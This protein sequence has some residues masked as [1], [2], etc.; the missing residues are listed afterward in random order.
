LD[1]E[2]SK[3]K[4]APFGSAQMVLAQ[5]NCTVCGGCLLTRVAHLQKKSRNEYDLADPAQWVFFFSDLLIIMIGPAGLLLVVPP[6][7]SLCPS[8][9]LMG[10][11]AKKANN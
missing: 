7:L 6:H 4:S 5:H 8:F 3:K 11:F 2:K 10:G 1:E 9:S